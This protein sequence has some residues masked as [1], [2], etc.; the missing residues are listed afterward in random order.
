MFVFSPPKLHI[1]FYNTYYSVKY[2]HLQIHFFEI[3]YILNLPG[4]LYS[5]K[6]AL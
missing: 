5:N 3:I 4:I 6:D 1:P 2:Y